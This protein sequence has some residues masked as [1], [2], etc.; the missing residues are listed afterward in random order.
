MHPEKKVNSKRY[1]IL[2][3]LTIYDTVQHHC[4]VNTT[5]S[6]SKAYIGLANRLQRSDQAIFSR[7]SKELN[8]LSTDRL[9]LMRKFA[10][11]Q[12]YDPNNWS[13]SI[14]RKDG[15]FE[16]VSIDPEVT[17]ERFSDKNKFFLNFKAVFSFFIEG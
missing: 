15:G 12:R 7:Y 17:L 9:D 11:D 4:I 6:K 8:E 3:D 1:S 16:F 14:S 13:I 10:Q 5:L 2:Q